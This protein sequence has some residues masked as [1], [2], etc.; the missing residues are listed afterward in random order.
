MIVLDTHALLWW[1]NGE[2]DSLS[3]PAITA[4]EHESNGGTILI[5]AISVWELSMLIERKRI[6]LAMDLRQWIAVLGQLD[7]IKFQPIDNEIALASTLLPGEFHKDPADR[8]IVATS[9]KLGAPLVTA[10]QKI[11]DYPHVETIW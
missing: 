1:A 2:H 10:D 6:D 3:S 11:R 9:R 8:F 4:I 7:Y 5:S